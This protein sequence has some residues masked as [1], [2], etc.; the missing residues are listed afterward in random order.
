MPN[1]TGER[2]TVRNGPPEPWEVAVQTRT[3]PY[4]RFGTRSDGYEYWEHR[5]SGENVRVYVHQLL[6]IA[7]GADP[8][9]LFGGGYDVHHRNS[10][11][12]DNRPSN[13]SVLPHAE[14]ARR[15]HTPDAPWTDED[16]V[17]RRLRET[18]APGP[19][20]EMG[21]FKA[22]ITN[23]RQKHGIEPGHK[24]GRPEGS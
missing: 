11:P 22:D 9:D 3:L 13:L 8:S 16:D 17:P 14:H 24:T 2:E 18:P 12:W 20:G 5:H 6:A 19:R 15:H 7:E 4:A 10:V 23:W 21:L 1:D